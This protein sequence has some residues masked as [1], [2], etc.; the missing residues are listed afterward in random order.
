MSIHLLPDIRNVML[1]QAG[2]LLPRYILAEVTLA[3]FGLGAGEAAA[4][5]GNLLAVLQQYDVLVSYW[6]M[7][8]P[9]CLILMTFLS[10]WNMTE[11]LS[12]NQRHRYF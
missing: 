12:T 4:S 2:L 5:W 9:A 10:C 7:W 1:I 11:A 6:W 8:L 3:F